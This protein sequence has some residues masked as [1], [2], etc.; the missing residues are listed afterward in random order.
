VSGQGFIGE[1]EARLRVNSWWEIA[2]VLGGSVTAP[3]PR[4][5]FENN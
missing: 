2:V 3:L 1:A 5:G 4:T